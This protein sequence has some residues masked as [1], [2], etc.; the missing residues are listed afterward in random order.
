MIVG[1]LVK[2]IVG[3]ALAAV[4]VFDGGSILVNFFTLDST[5]ND[6]AN[7]V[8]TDMASGTNPTS[9]ALEDKAETLA[10]EA[11][12]KLLEF[13]ISGDDVVH[14]KLRRKA[15]TLVVGKIDWI[16]HWARATADGK[17][18]QSRL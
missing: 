18:G 14:V 8:A 2:L 16:D 15:S 10:E 7:A 13:E 6:I 11:N 1:W 5:A 9:K 3:L 17:Q 4:V 12:A